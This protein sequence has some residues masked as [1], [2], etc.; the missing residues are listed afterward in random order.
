ME[1]S[2]II[3]GIIV[4]KTMCEWN[5]TIGDYFIRYKDDKLYLI[6]ILTNESWVLM[7]K[8]ILD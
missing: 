8:I 1:V 4:T 5:K 2:C 7:Y 6:L 3:F